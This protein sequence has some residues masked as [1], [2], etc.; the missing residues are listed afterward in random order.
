MNKAEYLL[1]KKDLREFPARLKNKKQKTT[2]MCDCLRMQRSDLFN[3]HVYFPFLLANSLQHCATIWL[4]Y[5]L[6][7][8][9]RKRNYS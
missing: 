9:A 6:N 4:I 5:S 1:L 2:S 7:H 3:T 8:K